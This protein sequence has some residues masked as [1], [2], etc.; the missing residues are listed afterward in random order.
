MQTSEPKK[1]VQAIKPVRGS[2]SNRATEATAMNPTPSRPTDPPPADLGARWAG[3]GGR[4]A[5]ATSQQIPNP[6]EL[7]PVRNLS[8]GWVSGRF[9]PVKKLPNL[10]EFAPVRHMAQIPTRFPAIAVQINFPYG[11]AQ[12]NGRLRLWLLACSLASLQVCW[13]LVGLLDG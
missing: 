7:A 4:T 10:C 6:G 5:E 2:S 13:L 9:G 12:K 8:S 1:T 11:G 3:G